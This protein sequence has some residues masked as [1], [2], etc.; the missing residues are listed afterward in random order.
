[1]KH[2]PDSLLSFFSREFLSELWFFSQ[3]VFWPGFLQSLWGLRMTF[4]FTDHFLHFFFFWLAFLP[5]PLD[6]F[7]STADSP[8]RRV[9]RSSCVMSSASL[10]RFQLTFFLSLIRY[11]LC[12]VK[13]HGQHCHGIFPYH[14]MHQYLL[15][16]N[17]LSGIFI[18]QKNL[19]NTDDIFKNSLFL[20]SI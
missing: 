16:T 10:C 4:Q 6:L 2:F 13:A 19:S 1:M 12:F 9:P 15:Y 14:I 7:L 11:L 8:D 20:I 17:S 18:G 3:N 5:E